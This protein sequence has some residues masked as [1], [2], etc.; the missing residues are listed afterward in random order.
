MSQ[1]AN[2]FGLIG[3]NELSPYVQKLLNSGGGGN[4]GNGSTGSSN[5][6]RMDYTLNIKQ[7]QW[8]EEDG[9]YYVI[10]VHNLQSTGLIVMGYETETGCSIQE[11]YKIINDRQVKVYNDKAI[12]VTINIID[13]IRASKGGLTIP[14]SASEFLLDPQED[15]Y[16]T[17]VVH[18]LDTYDIAIN[19]ID[20]NNNS[21]Y[22]AYTKIDN[23]SVR[24]FTTAPE[25]LYVNIVPLS[26]K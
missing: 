13:V 12:D 9:V 3:Y 15:L 11:A 19:V 7:D 4:G 22:V 18:G 25:N 17:K 16:T 10:I 6:I 21:V 24:I 23:N 26:T 20:G 2:P 5:G 14:K 8:I 1:H